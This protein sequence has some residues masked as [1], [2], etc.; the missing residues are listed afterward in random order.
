M[1]LYVVNGYRSPVLLSTKREIVYHLSFRAAAVTVDAVIAACMVYLLTR[2]APRFKRSRRIVYRL[3]ILTI[4][5]GAFTAL[6]VTTILILLVVRPNTFD[7]CIF[8]FPLC[9]VY[10][11]T[12]LANLNTREYIRGDC[13]PNTSPD[14]EMS[15]T[16]LPNSTTHVLRQL[17]G[18]HRVINVPDRIHIHVQR[19]TEQ[20]DNDRSTTSKPEPK[21]EH[22]CSHDDHVVF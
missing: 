3:L 11:S 20:D 1:T 19:H 18:L 2:Q 15:T 16:T 4:S 8:D 7:W 13:E 5:S 6:L 14:I 10:L 9:S 22:A 21:L 17:R 12:L